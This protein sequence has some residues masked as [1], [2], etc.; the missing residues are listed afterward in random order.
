M[1]WTQLLKDEVESTYRTTARLLDKVDAASLGWKPQ[2]GQNWMTVGQLIKHLASGC[3]APCKGFVTGDWGLP[4]GMKFEDIPPEEMLPPAEKMPAAASV[5][6]ARKELA[7]DKVL[8]LAMIEQAG[9]ENLANR[10]IAAPWDPASKMP[11][12]RQLLS[13]VQHLGSHKAQLFYYLK[14][15]GKPVNTGDMWG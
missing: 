9:E 1:Q 6:E 14:L 13:M 4:E 10:M 3:G 5:E 8:A 15:Q 2:S 11:L 12:G 7:E